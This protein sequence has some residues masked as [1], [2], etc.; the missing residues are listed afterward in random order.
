MPGAFELNEIFGSGREVV[1]AVGP[2]ERRRYIQ[3]CYG[4]EKPWGLSRWV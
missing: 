4:K 3:S 2:L 1:S